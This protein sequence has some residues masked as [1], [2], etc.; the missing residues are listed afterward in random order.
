MSGYWACSLTCGSLLV[1]HRTLLQG[2]FESVKAVL[3][4]APILIAYLGGGSG[5]PVAEQC[6]WAL[7]ELGGAGGGSKAGVG[8]GCVCV[9]LPACVP[10]YLLATVCLPARDSSPVEIN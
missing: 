5:L 6:A 3:S 10:A 2:E 1:S 7:G 8:G 9:W 4:A